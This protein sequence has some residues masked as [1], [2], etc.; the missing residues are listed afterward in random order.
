MKSGIVTTCSELKFLSFGPEIGDFNSNSDSAVQQKFDKWL[1]WVTGLF[2]SNKFGDEMRMLQFSSTNS[3]ES[4]LARWSEALNNHSFRLEIGGDPPVDARFAEWP[5]VRKGGSIYLI[6]LWFLVGCWFFQLMKKIF[7]PDSQGPIPLDRVNWHH[8]GEINANYLVLVDPQL[9]NTGRLAGISGIHCVDLRIESEQQAAKHATESSVLF[10]DHF[11]FNIDN[12]SHNQARLRL[13]ERLLYNVRCRVVIVSSIDVDYY[14][15]EVDPA[16][17]AD[18]P[19]AASECLLRWTR[20]LGGFRHA[21]FE[22]SSISTFETKLEPYRQV[23]QFKKLVQWIDDECNHTDYLRDLGMDL[24]T[25]YRS[26]PDLDLQLLRN[27]LEDRTDSYYALLWSTLTASERL[28]LYQLAKDGWANAKNHRAIRQLQRKGFVFTAPMFRI[29]NESFRLFVL[30]AQDQREIA[31]WEQVGAQSSWRTLKFGLVATAVALAAWLF[32]A[33]K[34]LFQ[35]VMGYVLTLGAAVTAIA[36]ILGSLRGR[37][38][39]AP[40]APDSN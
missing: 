37:L 11:D 22:S 13:L 30:K 2:P 29:M 28:T 33:Q 34:D 4:P 23:P 27:E 8:G 17:L 26:A 5:G 18:D 3:P 36:N 20:V 12:R 40:K 24:F 9:G 39:S 19:Q 38:A 14:L 1:E 7:L 21:A 31:E 15:S 6:L 35:G 10:L 25:R 32:Y 16:V